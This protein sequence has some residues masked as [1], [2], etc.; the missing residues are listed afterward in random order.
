VF[1]PVSQ[2]A[3]AIAEIAQIY[4]NGDQKQSITKHSVPILGDRAQYGSK[5]KVMKRLQ[6]EDVRLLF[7]L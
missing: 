1:A 3:I 2:L 7:L 5:G 6:N 4:I